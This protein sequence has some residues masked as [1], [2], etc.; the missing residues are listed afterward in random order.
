VIEWFNAATEKHDLDIIDPTNMSKWPSHIENLL[1]E[2]GPGAAS[3]SK[4]LMPCPPAGD[5]PQLVYGLWEKRLARFNLPGETYIVSPWERGRLGDDVGPNAAY[6]ILVNLAATTAAIENSES[7]FPFRLMLAK[8]WEKKLIRTK[9]AHDPTD[10]L[11]AVLLLR[12]EGGRSK[13]GRFGNPHVDA[14]FFPLFVIKMPTRDWSLEYNPKFNRNKW[15][16]P[17]KLV[18][19]AGN[20]VD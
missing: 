18:N 16:E 17:Y 1:H 4:I 3:V 11:C 13:E 12:F 20:L 2:A 19:Y 10:Q 14:G 15:Y 7:E 9:Y 8:G 5:E 6:N